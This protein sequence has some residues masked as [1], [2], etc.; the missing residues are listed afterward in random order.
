MRPRVVRGVLLAAVAL[1]CV[2][3][4]APADSVFGIRGLGLLGR[5]LSARAAGT[6]G[7]FALFDPATA[8]NPA[9]FGQWRLPSGWAVGSPTWRTYDDGVTS[10]ALSSTRFPLFGVA[11]P[12]G[13]RL[14]IAA[15]IGEFLDR[16]WA[17][18]TERDTLIRDTAV[19]MSDDVRSVG[20]VS[21]LRFAVAYALSGRVLVGLGVHALAGS[22]QIGVVRRFLDSAGTG[23][24]PYASYTDLAVTDLTGA[25]VSAGV[26]VRASS[27][28]AFS[29]MVRLNSRL[30]AK[31]TRGATAR[32]G[33][34]VELGVGAYVAPGRGIGIGASVGYQTWSRATDAL[35]AAGQPA[36]RDVWNVAAGAEFDA[37]RLLGRGVPLRVG[38][39]WRQLPF[40]ADAGLLSESALS[41]GLGL[42]F[43]GGRATVDIS[44]EFGTRAAGDQRERFTTG[45]VGVV[46]RP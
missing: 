39:R 4:D 17:F 1:G 6:G 32:V 7:G 30:T 19:T 15:S 27:A 31:P 41:G 16:T 9:A 5:P 25:S 46:V 12:A 2:V 20:G 14:V 34:P 42:D 8:L 24:E 21:D 44:A 3:P 36:A 33:M 23:L 28:V 40:A 29:G 38:Y 13:R 43:A 45:F 18:R 37:V 35:V 10:T 26:Q 11:V 22:S